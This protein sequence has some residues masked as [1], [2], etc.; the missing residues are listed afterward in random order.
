VSEFKSKVLC[1][2]EE[3]PETGQEYAVTKRGKPMVLVTPI[4]QKR[5]SAFGTWR[6]EERGDIVNADWSEL[7]RASRGKAR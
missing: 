2:V 7:F 3:A 6:G 5:R 1:I 4:L